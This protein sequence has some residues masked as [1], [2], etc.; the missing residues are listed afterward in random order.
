LLS[1]HAEPISQPGIKQFVYRKIGG[2]KKKVRTSPMH[3]QYTRNMRGVDAANQLWGTYSC[4]IHSHKWWHRLFSYMLDTIVSNMWI[5]YS[6]L[7]FCFLEEPL[8][9]LSFQLQLANDLSLKW[10]GRKHGYSIF[11]PLVPAAH[12]PKSMGKKRGNVENVCAWRTYKPSLPWLPM[13]HM[14]GCMLLG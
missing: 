13:P 6:D 10:A 2:K 9:Y 7:R 14:Q 11:S 8:T 1:T 3:L 4:I 12:G 5:I